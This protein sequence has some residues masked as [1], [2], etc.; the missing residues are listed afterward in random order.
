ML[1]RKGKK[2]FFLH[3]PHQWIRI[4]LM[5]IPIFHRFL[6][7]LRMEIIILFF[8]S[9]LLLAVGFPIVAYPYAKRLK[10]EYKCPNGIFIFA[11][12]TVLPI[13][14][15]PFIAYVIFVAIWFNRALT[16]IP[17]LLYP[18]CNIYGLYLF[19]SSFKKGERNKSIWYL[20]AVWAAI[21]LLAIL[22]FWIL[23]LYSS[24]IFL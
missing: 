22:F 7:F 24:H 21:L 2:M 12:F 15:T 5:I 20:V 19:Y 4:F 17:L 9:S 18:F 11:I 14:A 23:S 3:L 16:T 1:F 8:A 10:K 13:F 6:L